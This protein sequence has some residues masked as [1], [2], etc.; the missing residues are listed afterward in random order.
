MRREAP[1]K[2]DPERNKLASLATGPYRV[3]KT[4]AKNDVIINAVW[5]DDT[6]SRDRVGPSPDA[7]GKGFRSS[8][9]TVHRPSASVKSAHGLL[10]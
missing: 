3:V 6:V 9:M 8:S 5:V 1:T 7:L 10:R 4:S 2:D